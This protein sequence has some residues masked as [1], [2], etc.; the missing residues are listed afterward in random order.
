MHHPDSV[1]DDVGMETNTNTENRPTTADTRLQRK[2]L[3][4]IERRTFCTLSTVS[5]AGRPH[6]AGVVYDSVG[7]T[8]WVH[9]LRSSRK[10]RNIAHEPNVAVCL[11]FRRMPMGP[12]F[13]IHAQATATLVDMDDPRVTELLDAGHLG[14]VSGHGALDMP[15]GVFA[16]IA[17]R[18]TIHSY[19][20]G[21]RIIDLARD[22]LNHGAASFPLAAS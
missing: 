4:T 3:R 14:H 5:A 11:P 21:A 12:P 6:V 20:P 22:P 16:A 2:I 18:G 19:G 8:L 9:T 1:H 10:A 13:T 17:L 15:D 7:T